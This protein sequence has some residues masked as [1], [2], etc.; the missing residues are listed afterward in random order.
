MSC[1]DWC[2]Y[3][4]SNC[5]G[6]PPLCSDGLAECDDG[7]LFPERVETLLR[8]CT[9]CTS[10]EICERLAEQINEGADPQDDITVVV[11]QRTH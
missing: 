3:D 1:T 9:G 7:R 6:S 10:A 11:I 4:T 5:T 8:D 2:T